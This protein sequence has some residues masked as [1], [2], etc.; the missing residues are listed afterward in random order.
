MYSTRASII[1]WIKMTEI[2]DCVKL[3]DGIKCPCAD[4]L[5]RLYL[6]K[7]RGN[8][9]ELRIKRHIELGEKEYCKCYNKN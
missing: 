6:T 4:K 2:R 3:I 5:R 7:P 9:S 1:N 8:Q